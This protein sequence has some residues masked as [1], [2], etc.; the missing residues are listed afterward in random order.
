[1]TEISFSDG[2]RSAVVVGWTSHFG[3]QLCATNE[4]L[5]GNFPIESWDSV[6][7]GLY[8]FEFDF[9]WYTRF[10]NHVD[11]MGWDGRRLGRIKR[12]EKMDGGRYRTDRRTDAFM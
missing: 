3:P 1:M 11:G 6:C 5:I 2:P 9:M 7:Y 4:I 8:R 12:K 10:I